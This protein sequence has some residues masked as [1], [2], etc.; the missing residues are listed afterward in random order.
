MTDSN[1]GTPTTSQLGDT[2]ITNN[3]ISIEERKKQ[4]YLENSINKTED[5][6]DYEQK[7]IDFDEKQ[8]AAAAEIQ[9]QDSR[10]DGPW[11]L[12]DYAKEAGSV[13]A[14]GLQDTAS[15]LVTA[16]ERLV[17]MITGE[18]SDEVFATGR[19]TPDFDP[20]TDP[21]NPIVTKTWIGNLARGFVHYGTM[22]VPIGGAAGA[23]T[24]VAPLAKSVGLFNKT[25]L[26]RGMARGAGADAL[27]RNS[28][29]HNLLGVVKKKFPHI[30]TPISTN[31]WDHPLMKT[32]KN[33]VEGMGLGIV[34]DGVAA[35]VGKGARGIKEAR[36]NRIKSIKEQVIEKGAT[37]LADP[38]PRGHKNKV[39]M[40]S[41]QG[42]PTSN[43]TIDN[44]RGQLDQIRTDYGAKEGS[45]DSVLTPVQLERWGEAEYQAFG[46]Q[47]LSSS[48]YQAEIAAIKAGQTTMAE[49]WGNTLDQVYRITQGREATELSSAEYFKEHIASSVEWPILNDKGEVIDKITTWFP[50]TLGSA[51]LVVGTLLREIRDLG[52]S[53]RE[54]QDLVD[55]NAVDGSA[56]AI[57]D[58]IL[59]ALTETKRTRMVMSDQFRKIGVGKKGKSSVRKELNE[60]LAEEMARTKESLVAMMK[61]ASDQKSDDLTKALWEV[62]SSID[63]VNN[64]DDFDAWVKKAIKGG[65]ID[66]RKQTGV[67]IKSLEGNFVHSVLSGPK[68]P[69]RAMMGTSTAT[70]LRPL[71]M[72][73]GAGMRGDGAAAR[74]G[75]ASLNAM[76]QA[77]P[78]SFT[79]FKT[80][81]NSYWNGDIATV[82]TRFYEGA[83]GN[84]QWDLIGNYIE[85]SPDVAWADKMWYRMAN[86]SRAWNNS[87]WLTYST[88]LMAATDDAF[89]YILGRS[90]MRKRSYLEAME[91]FNKGEITDITPE[92]LK[93][94]EDKFYAEIFDADGNIKDAAVEAA[95]KEVTLT[96][97]L[98]GFS[99]GLNDVFNN[100]PLAKPF[101]LFA[102]TGVNGLALTAKHTP[103]FNRLVTEVNDIN[104][105]SL[106][107][108]L[109][110][111]NK[112]G[113][114]TP[115][116]LTFAKDLQR[117]R[118][119][120]G[121][122][123]IAM[124]SWAYMSDSLTGNG[125]ADRQ[126][127][128][129]W[130]DAGWK[131]RSIKLGGVWVGYDSMEPFNQIFS[132][133]GDIGD[134]TELM[135]EEWTEDN[136]QKLGLVIAQGITSKSYLA[137]MTQFV[138]LFSGRPGQWERITAN[139]MNNT[140]PL[141]G[142]RNE[143]G[144]LFTPYTRELGSGIT[145]AIRNRNLISENIAGDGQL[146]IKYDLLNGQPLKDHNFF[147][148]AFN[149]V[150][151]IQLNLDYSPGRRLLFD[152][153]YDLR[154]STYY[155]PNGNDLSESP[156]IRSMFQEAIGKQNIEAQLNRLAT[157]PKIIESL[158]EYN[159]DLRNGN[160]GKYE[161]KDYYHNRRI[162]VIFERA[163]RR[164][165]AQILNQQAVQTL[166]TE[167]RQR[168]LSQ[169]KKAFTSGG[170]AQPLLNM[171]K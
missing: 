20:F 113:I 75:L 23:I 115:Q 136:L 116:D 125:P 87:K 117:G 138:E 156:V 89:G 28:Q 18:Y 164:A 15:S 72:A 160:R 97:D 56:K 123:L 151:P 19:Y 83:S 52:I 27:S 57:V 95:R 109:T 140:V 155:S 94:G 108:D 6:I 131:P 85:T 104:L 44:V 88:K 100:F 51:D 126:K 33:V 159:R 124:A 135:G 153:G 58:K 141:A 92:M 118:V 157:S 12:G 9:P 59:T 98:T 168:D 48:R 63:D 78:E 66:G 39:I 42:S 139:L 7:K 163:R 38:N 2:S 169:T 111:L 106:G 36:A 5:R 43:G 55:L 8:A 62:F 1:F 10:D 107:G 112:Y 103:L 41:H 161:T 152:S 31:D 149:A 96:Q 68:T 86:M 165:W 13:V 91:N 53:G 144:K 71:S 101:F 137:G 21:D 45:T 24:K 79:L 90:E 32:F 142:L 67:L 40:D 64:L 61:L 49:A 25:R 105:A 3:D 69:L 128:Q 170:S 129:M 46:K 130:L 65:T 171:Y 14:G 93:Q 119:A 50:E 29:D 26:I 22:M 102:R 84:D 70:F 73:I 132:I 74:A 148:R 122:S 54:M 154:M 127:R 162:K 81:L 77:I 30:D 17:D 60:A 82:K 114:Y 110:P 4:E 76:M 167:E 35:A 134:H 147:V 11:D 37:E 121:S 145:D 150:S 146:P 34:M 16:P 47:V 133:I 99:K 80:R 158:A 143:L 120:M 166:I